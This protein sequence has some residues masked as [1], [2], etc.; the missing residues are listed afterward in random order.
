MIE[1][2]RLKNIVIFLQSIKE[3]SFAIKEL[4]MIHDALLKISTFYWH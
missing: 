3:Y 1:T 4:Y 2:G